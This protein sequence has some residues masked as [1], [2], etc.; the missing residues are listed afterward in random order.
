MIKN[1]GFS[2]YLIL[3][4]NFIAYDIKI[5]FGLTIFQLLYLLYLMQQQNVK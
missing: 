2:F 3:S 1:Y 4:T 5:L